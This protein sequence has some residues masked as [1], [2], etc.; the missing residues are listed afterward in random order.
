[1]GLL[2]ES[3]AEIDQKNN[4][5]LRLA[6]AYLN[7]TNTLRLAWQSIDHVHCLTAGYVSHGFRPTKKPGNK[8][9]TWI[10]AV[11]DAL[12]RQ[13]ATQKGVHVWY[14]IRP[15]W[16]FHAKG[17]WL[18]YSTNDSHDT[19]DCGHR[20]TNDEDLVCVTHGSGNYGQ[21]SQF[22]DMES[23][24]Y[25]ILPPGSPLADQYKEEWNTMCAYAVLLGECEEQELKWHLRWL[26]PWLKK[27]F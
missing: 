27:F 19:A 4:A 2:E 10:P 8:G 11:F 17:M 5:V 25:L 24:L 26:L 13:T 16:T 22:R 1:M 9:K 6:S 21:R 15:D 14:Y 20:F 12:A 3:E 18:S 7:T 23:N